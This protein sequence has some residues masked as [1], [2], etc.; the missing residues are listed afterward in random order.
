MIETIRNRTYYLWLVVG[1]LWVVGMLNYLDR[2][3]ITTMRDSIKAD[4][5]MTDAQFG[6]LTSVFLWIYAAL[7]PFA[8]YLADRFSRSRVIVISL[9]V[10]SLMTWLTA[11]C[12]TVNQLLVVRALMGISE[13]CYIPAALA[14]IADYHR[15]TTRSLATG[16]HMSGIYAGSALGGVGGILAEEIGWRTSFTLFGLGGIVYAVVLYFL[17]HDEAKAE[18]K[19]DISRPEEPSVSLFSAL[20]T[21]L[22]KP[23][24]YVLLAHWSLL[25]IPGWFVS[26]WLPTYL[27]EHFNM[28][29]GTAGMSATGYVQIAAFVGVLIGGFLAD[30]WIRRNIRGRILVPAIALSL[31]C[32]A[33][34]MTASTNVFVLAIAGLAVYGFSRGCSD[35]NMMPILCQVVDSRYRATGYGLLNCC[36]CFAGGLMIYMSGA[37]KDNHVE[38]GTVFQFAAVGMLASGLI[39]LLARPRRV[40][41]AVLE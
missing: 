13:A 20:R 16:I 12:H 11:H 19:T 39:L 35:S 9:L 6:L 31:A 15:G 41:N 30:R 18:L 14:L 10:W 4:I 28:S 29:Q 7:S 34:Y 3:T 22:A 38:L 24:Y 36:S 40:E 1:L 5:A 27:K 17:L 26:G 2:L 37:L 25:A 32:P 8:G 23:S 33:L 21:L